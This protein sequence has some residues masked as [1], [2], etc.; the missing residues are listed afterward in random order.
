MDLSDRRGDNRLLAA[1]PLED[2][3]RWRYLLVPVQ[4]ARGQ[5]LVEAGAAMPHVYFP[6][7]A[8]AA[9]ISHT[10]SGESS[11]L[12]LVGPE[13]MVGV[14]GFMAS[15]PVSSDAVVV[16]AG[17]GWRMRVTDLRAEF[18]ASTTVRQI[19]LHYTQALIVQLAQTAVC[20]R[21]HGIDQALCRCMLH[22]LDRSR[23]TDLH[24]TH[25]GI[26][27]LM[28]VRRVGITQ[29]ATRLQKA[30]LI[31]YE[32]GHIQV[33]DRAGLERNACDCYALVRNAYRR[34]LLPPHVQSEPAQRRLI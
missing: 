21:H 3:D 22:C 24:M 30:G 25:E 13:G 18:E 12:A 16:S 29:A 9:W 10:P 32:R 33:L 19:L 6:M 8:V 27:M 17:T 7:S 26:A 14:S 28:G 5:I 11:E 20:H 2:W 31:R 15:G 34:F 4:W 23:T 1:L